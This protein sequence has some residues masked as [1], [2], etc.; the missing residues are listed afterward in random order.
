MEILFILI[1]SLL[2]NWMMSLHSNYQYAKSNTE[3][4]AIMLLSF[5]FAIVLGF[6]VI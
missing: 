2:L 1:F 5:A 4:L 6:I 3:R